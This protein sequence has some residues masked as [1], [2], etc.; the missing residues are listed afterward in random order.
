ME[1]RTV[2]DAAVLADALAEKVRR[3]GE[4]PAFATLESALH[5][6]DAQGYSIESLLPSGA[7]ARLGAALAVVKSGKSFWSAYSEVIRETLCKKDSEL[8]KLSKAGL[9]GSA[10]ALVPILL[11]GL[12]LPVAAISVVVPIAAIIAALGVDAF[13]RWSTQGE[14]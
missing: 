2:S 6:F 9:S 11:T 4:E 3:E 14:T 13:C 8:Q 12:G 10:G 1:P 5:A 7:D